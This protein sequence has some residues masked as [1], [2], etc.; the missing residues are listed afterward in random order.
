MSVIGTCSVCVVCGRG[1][2]HLPQERNCS[3]RNGEED[4][5]TASDMLRWSVVCVCVGWVVVYGG[6]GV[7]MGWV[8]GW[9]CFAVSNP[10]PF[11]LLSG[12]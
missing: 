7:R 5:H 2:R 6:G 9:V 8:G 10:F 11:L 12:V 4:C 1:G 3:Q